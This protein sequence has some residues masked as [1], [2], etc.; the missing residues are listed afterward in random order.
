MEPVKLLRV[1]MF[2]QDQEFILNHKVFKSNKK[3]QREIGMQIREA[4]RDKK[5]LITKLIK[6]KPE[7]SVVIQHCSHFRIQI[8]NYV[9]ID[10]ADLS[11][12]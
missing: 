8:N 10:L 6:Q 4:L 5:R 12:L 9:F 2:F 1:T 11:G 7:F 3:S